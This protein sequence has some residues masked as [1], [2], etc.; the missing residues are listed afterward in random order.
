MILVLNE[1][2]NIQPAKSSALPQKAYTV[3]EIAGMLKLSVRKAYLFC[4]ET[5]DFKVMRLGRS[6]RVHKESFDEW[7]SR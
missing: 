6:I 4:N 2:I 7:L 5:T 1:Q 3:P